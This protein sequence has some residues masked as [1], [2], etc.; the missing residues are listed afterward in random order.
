MSRL[1]PRWYQRETVDAVL[2]ALR[3]AS[4]SNPLA[5][6]VTGG[7][8]ALIAAMLMEELNLISPG[9][10]VL[11]L[12]PSQELV[13][14]NFE[15]AANYLPPALVRRMGIYCAGLNAKDR[16][17]Q[18]I[19]GT[20]QSV[21]RQARRFGRLDYVVI[22][23]AHLTDVS[24]ESTN[25]SK[26]LKALRD[27][28]PNLRVIGLTATPFRMQ[29]LRVV[30]LTECGLFTSL[31]YDLT[32]GRNY[33]RLVREGYLSP[34]VAPSVYFP[35]IDTEGVKTK[36]GD[37]DEAELAQR[38]MK[39]TR[40]CVA[41]A[42]ENAQDR[43]HFMWFGVNIEHAKMIHKALTDAGESAVL[44][45]GELEKGERVDGVDAYLRK[46]H[47]HIVSVAMLTTGFNA[48]FVDCLVVLRPTRS[49]VLWRQIV[50]RIFRPYPGKDNGLVLD[51]GG[52]FARHG[53]INAEVTAGDSRSGLWECTDEMKGGPP[54]TLPSGETWRPPQRERS[55]IRF[56]TSSEQEETDLRVL[57][58]LMDA[59]QPAPACGFLNDPEHMTCRQCGRPRQ[60]FL[61]R[62]IRTERDRDP[63]AADS[64]YELHDEEAITLRDEVCKESRRIPVDD[65]QT[66]PEGGG[67]IR[68]D[69]LTAEQSNFSLRLDFD[70]STAD[71]KFYAFARKYWEKSTGMKVPTEG[72]RAVLLRQAV[73]KPL[74]IELTRF[75]NGQ[76]FL[77][78]LRF[79]HGDKME[80]FRYDPSF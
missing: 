51:A 77:T 22:D 57:L 76:V 72:Y 42:L 59:E 60:G 43:K 74:D 1:T 50:G 34:I 73:Q 63:F 38:A 7:G 3:V 80:T 52:N 53:A 70:R 14:Q 75:E 11:S 21:A 54:V 49:L 68:F 26:T 36:G 44:I 47:R 64:G 28:N 65:M 9:C 40:E 29:G 31:V 41:V 71:P 62:R 56:L 48:K 25:A 12:V 67:V 23:E 46:Q 13:K 4:N 55:A 19:V 30:P 66:T 35:Q 58:G 33:N 69:F 10:R 32:S 37:F 24:K 39:V 2:S 16:L 45:H 27:L 78:E 20:I 15:E 6:V 17:S 18:F 79:V 61:H 8:K 5:A